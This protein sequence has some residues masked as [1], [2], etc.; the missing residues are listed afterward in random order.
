[1]SASLSGKNVANRLLVI[2][3]LT[4]IV[5]GLLFS[6]KSLEWGASAIGG[7]LAALLPNAFFMNFA[8]RHQ[9]QI[10]AKG[11]L[12]WSFAL[13]EAVKVIVTF[14]L[15]VVALACFKAVFLPLIV[16]CISALVV[17]ILASAVINNQ[18]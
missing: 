8:W 2:Q 17:Q 7:G 11:R 9:A 6:L 12:A 14:I 18:G 5:I 3:L 1:M 13:G 4:V 16:T 10:P 15:L